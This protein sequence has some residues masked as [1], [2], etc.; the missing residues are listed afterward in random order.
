VHVCVRARVCVC[1]SLLAPLQPAPLFVCVCVCVFKCVC[2]RDRERVCV[3]VCVRVAT[4]PGA[5]LLAPFHQ[6]P[7]DSCGGRREMG[8]KQ[9]KESERV[10]GRGGGM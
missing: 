5:P 9:T 8:L 2:A 1:V 6:T 7:A 4:L 3:C 10:G